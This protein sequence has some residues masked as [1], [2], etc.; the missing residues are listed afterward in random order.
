MKDLFLINIKVMKE[1]TD[2][3]AD[4]FQMKGHSK[5]NMQGRDNVVKE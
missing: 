5:Q 3:S 1:K 2:E 4:I